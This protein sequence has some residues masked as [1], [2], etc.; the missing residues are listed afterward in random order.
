MLKRASILG[1]PVASDVHAI[2]SIEDDYN[3]DYMQHADILF[4]SH[5]HLPCPPEEW[6]RQLQYLRQLGSKIVR[7]TSSDSA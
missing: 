3:R 4:M 1:I 6:V 5:E 2:S 7:V